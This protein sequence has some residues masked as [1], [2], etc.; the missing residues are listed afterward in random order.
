MKAVVHTRYGPPEVAELK[1]VKKPVPLNNELLVKV[2]ASTVNRT[3]S[4]FRS[5][6]YFISRFFSGLFKPKYTIL[7]CEF[8]G[9]IEAIGNDVTQFEM[10][11][12]VFGYNDKSFGSHAEYL[13]IAEDE[14]VATMPD[15][16][17]FER[18]APITEG[19][20]Y[21]LCDINAAKVKK[22]Q[23]VLVN[24]ATGA[25]GSAAVQLLKH[26]G[27]NITAVCHTK[28]LILVKSLGADVVIDYTQTDFTTLNNTFDF[29]FDAVG[30]SSF[31]ACKPLL[32]D[33]GIYIST[34]L[35]KHS[36]NVFLAITT[37]FFSNKK[38]LFPLPVSNKAQLIFL[39]ELVVIGAYLPVID[40]V[41]ALDEIV[42]AYRYVETGM[43]T[44]NVVIKIC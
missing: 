30:K 9:I 23:D 4:G 31:A 18:A 21:A 20:H 25:I 22:G 43:K 13:T 28:D 5:A 42:E 24:G 34:E 27:A 17:S 1:A 33:K 44:G 35:G 26:I 11:D 19:A 8:A 15:G 40:R 7:G 38:V 10:G 39:K 29:V 14:A 16:I 12:K 6:Q 32:K 2:F 36:A 37:R 41:Y 3:D